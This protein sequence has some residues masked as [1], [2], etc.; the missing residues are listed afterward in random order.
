MSPA[1]MGTVIRFVQVSA[2]ERS[3]REISCATPSPGMWERVARRPACEHM[4]IETTPCLC[5][6]DIFSWGTQVI[7]SH[8][9]IMESSPESAVATTFLLEEQHVHVMG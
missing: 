2:D 5:G 3:H 4:S 1:G 8:N 7:V 9:T 6:C